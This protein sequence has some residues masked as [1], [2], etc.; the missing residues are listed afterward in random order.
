MSVTFHIPGPL[1]TFTGGQ[2]VVHLSISP[3]SLREAL[4]A[5]FA[6]Y[7]ALRDRVVTEQGTVREHVNVFVDKED[8]RYLGGLE[9]PLGNP[10][11][12]SIVPA[13]SGGCFF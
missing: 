8:V 13:V 12:I 7:P 9:T 2:R 6:A 4:D 11:E 10:V 5:L 1:L 3:R